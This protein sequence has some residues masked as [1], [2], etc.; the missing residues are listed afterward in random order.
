M[1]NVERDMNT[2]ENQKRKEN[3]KRSAK[4]SNTYMFWR[5][6]KYRSFML[7]VPFCPNFAQ[8]LHFSTHYSFVTDGRTDGKL[9]GRTHPLTE[10]RK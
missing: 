5:S 7:L 8:K 2:I 3:G 1:K 10:I 6:P 4:T 9:D